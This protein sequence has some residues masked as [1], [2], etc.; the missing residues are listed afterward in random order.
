MERSQRGS[1]EWVVQLELG[2][3]AA[4]LAVEI[5]GQR[6]QIQNLS[7]KTPVFAKRFGNLAQRK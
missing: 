6:F 7:L 3:I 4:H 1:R 2:C 5:R